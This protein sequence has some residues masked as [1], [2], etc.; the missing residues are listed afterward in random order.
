MN[1][2]RKLRKNKE[3]NKKSFNKIKRLILRLSL[4]T[5]NFVFATF[6]WFLYQM[7]LETTVDVKVSSWKMNFKENNTSVETSIEFDLENFYPG[8][9]D[10]VKTIEIE[11]LGERSAA[12]E[13]EVETLKILGTTYHV[14]EAAQAG[15]PANTL[16]SGKTVESGKNVVKV[17][18]NATKFPYEIILTYSQEIYTPSVA[19]PDRNKGTFEIRLTWPY[20]ITG[21]ETQIQQKNTLDTKW[22]YDIANFYKNLPADSEAKAMEITINAIAKQ[23]ID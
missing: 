2:I 5:F 18:N 15:D 1:K 20:E 9:E 4:I 3:K 14:K 6:A 7:T 12:I 23:I 16:Y 13:Y 22:G 8:M 10:Y 21:T 17:L 19:D 11:N